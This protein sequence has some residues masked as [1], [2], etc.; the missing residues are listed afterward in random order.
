MS[1]W[2][3]VVTNGGAD[4]LNEWAGGGTLQITGAASGDATVPEAALLVQRNISGIRREVALTG[5]RKIEGGT[6]IRIQI[7]AP[8]AQGYILRQLGIWAALDGGE[9]VLLALFQANEGIP[10]PSSAESPDFTYTFYGILALDNTGP[11]EVLVDANALISMATLQDCLDQL[12][13]DDVGAV[14]VTRKVNNKALSADITL[15]PSDVGAIASVGFS[16]NK[17]DQQDESGFE[18][19]LDTQL[20]G[21][22]P[23]SLKSINFGVYPAISSATFTGFLYKHQKE[24]LYASLW[25]MTY[26]GQYCTKVKTNGTW[27]KHHLEFFDSGRLSMKITVNTDTDRDADAIANIQSVYAD[28]PDYSEKWL[29]L[30]YSKASESL[31]TGGQGLLHLYRAHAG[32]GFAMFYLYSAAGNKPPIYGLTKYNGVWGTGW[33]NMDTKIPYASVAPKA[34]G[35]AAVGT[36]AKVAREDHVHPAQTSVTGNAGTATAPNFQ[37][38]AANT[39]LNSITAKGWYNCNRDATVATLKN[40]PTSNAFVLEVLI[41]ASITQRITEYLPEG[42]TMWVRSHYDGRWGTWA[43]VYTS[44]AKPTAADVGAA[45]S[46]HTHTAAQVGAWPASEANGLSVRI[47]HNSA[48]NARMAVA[49]GESAKA[50]YECAT[51]LGCSATAAED[52]ATALGC[53]SNAIGRGTVALGASSRANGAF[54]TAIGETSRANGTSSIALADS[55]SASNDAD[56]AIGSVASASGFYSIALGSVASATGVSSIALGCRATATGENSIALGSWAKVTAN[57]TIQLGNASTLAALCCLKALTVTSDER[58]KTDIQDIGGAVDFLKRVRAFSY[59]RNDRDLY[60]KPEEE[61]SEEERKAADKYGFKPYRQEDHAAGT[62]KRK[63]R[64]V[65]VGAQTVQ[66]AL[67]ETF[68]TADYADIVN[69]SLHDFPP[70]EVPDWVESHLGVT[71]EKFIPFLIK[72]VQELDARL[73]EVEAAHA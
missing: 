37:S 26:G 70:E 46:G 42:P 61:W 17:N 28:M 35:T 20:E 13:A 40:C 69:D 3:G 29:M 54:S 18:A 44:L 5:Y 65:G 45:A 57:N 34:A 6:Q 51:A 23:N 48:V 56:I 39:D 24:G 22:A 4:I 11:L 8:P 14:P 33:V 71:Y 53:M 60:N 16:Y 72:A 63:R 55:S 12:A 27:G 49:L 15:T 66:Q 9:P 43:K 38:I 30:D 25:G 68:G 62:L 59:V 19:W 64:R 2:N 1:R 50:L 10:I 52:S 67:I 31:G 58:D 73:L 21:M 47:G 41:S 7:P 32:Y 36:S